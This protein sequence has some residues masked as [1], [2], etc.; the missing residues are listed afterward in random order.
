MR[1]T[2][3]LVYR[4][5]NWFWYWRVREISGLSNDRLDSKCFSKQGRKRHF[6]RMQSSAS[7]PDKFALV[8]G[9]TL[10][11]LVDRW[12]TPDDGGPGPF[13]CATKD[14]NSRFW[15]FL[16]GRNL[17]LSVYSDYIHR[18][19]HS[20]GWI[21][22]KAGDY[23]L[24]RTFLGE[25]E[26]AIEPG[27]STAYSAMLHKLVNEAT[28]DTSAVL[29]ALFREAIHR[30]DLEQ[31][32]AIR[33]ALSASIASMG[34]RHNIPSSVTRLI[35]QLVDDR[36]LSNRCVTELH[37]RSE[38][39]TPVKSGIGSRARVREF[40]AWVQWYTGRP[41]GFDSTGYGLF[42]L[43]PRSV[44][45]DWL[46][47]NRNF[48]SEVRMEADALKHD[49]LRF[50]DSIVPEYRRLSE[51]ARIRAK[52]LL[53]HVAPPEVEPVRFYGNARPALEMENLPTPFKVQP[54]RVAQSND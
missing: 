9:K 29:L 44:R 35:S 52:A 18:F 13:V 7:A 12:D 6:E 41:P 47:S 10:L 3:D 2:E 19:A 26:P 48:L 53:S 40:Q 1:P 34:H 43:V 49:H 22:A 20:R 33:T 50:R 30:V 24:Y 8:E 14:F 51:E 38:T 42:P 39:N 11:T 27:V 16:A 5:R 31:A 45:T 36:V 28:P 4:A 46:E 37:W 17:D 21:R 23:G 54:T 15:D 32:I 25:E